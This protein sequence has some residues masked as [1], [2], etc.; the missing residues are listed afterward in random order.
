MAGLIKSMSD[1]VSRTDIQGISSADDI[2]KIY[3]RKF[4]ISYDEILDAISR[5]FEKDFWMKPYWKWV[6]KDRNLFYD[7]KYSND[8]FNMIYWDFFDKSVSDKKEGE[9]KQENF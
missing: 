4:P 6:S 8:G 3:D 7:E 5:E 2:I 9:E 1:Y